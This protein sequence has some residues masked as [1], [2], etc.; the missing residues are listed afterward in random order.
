[1]SNIL[2]NKLPNYTPPESVWENIREEL[3][4]LKQLASYEPPESVWEN[5]EKNNVSVKVRKL[6]FETQKVKAALWSLRIAASVALLLVGFGA[7][8]SYKNDTDTVKI[9]Y[10]QEKLPTQTQV[11]TN[12]NLEQQYAH[13]QA[14]CQKR[15]A[16]C[17][18]P[19]F[20]NLKQELDDLT[21]AGN[22]LKEAL[23][24]YNT[25]ATLSTQLSEIE[26][27]RADIL[28]KLTASI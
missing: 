6:S 8:L 28:Q 18:K 10:S 5:I 14:I 9:S 1:M 7:Y 23:G 13:I 19:E 25:D 2:K 4:P 11:R 12:P 17:E 21:A 24:A 16:V 20:K 15:I 27:E 22:Q 3:N 26:R